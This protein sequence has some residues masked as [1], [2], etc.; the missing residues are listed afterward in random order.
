MKVKVKCIL[1]GFNSLKGYFMDYKVFLLFLF[2]TKLNVF[3]QSINEIIIYSDEDIPYVTIDGDGR[4]NGGTT[5][6][7][8]FK[9][10][11][12]LN[13]SRTKIERVPWARAYNE[14]ISK[15]N[16]MI[17]P[18]VKTSER[19]EKLDYLFKLLESKVYFYKLRSRDDIKISNFNDAKKFTVC[20]QRDDYRA[21]FLLSKGFKFLDEATSSTLNVKK[22]LEGRCDLIISTEIGIKNKIEHLKYEFNLVEN[23]ISIDELDSDLY[24]AIN[25]NTPEKIK[26]VIKN[27]V[28][29]V[30]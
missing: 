15:P 24:L 25:K 11:R 2:F 7:P 26:E 29:S 9:L 1:N 3:A 6:E 10:L 30:K 23:L 4:I 5:T 27:S 16:I 22:F 8:V 28:K 17:Y 20:V 19:L 18:I 14:A 12:H 13:L 21:K